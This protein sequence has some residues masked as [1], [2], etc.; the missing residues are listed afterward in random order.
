M[1]DQQSI[2]AS[3]VV[4]K[5]GLALFRNPGALIICQD[6]IHFGQ[7]HERVCC[8]P[9]GRPLIT[10]FNPVELKAVVLQRFEVTR[11]TRAGFQ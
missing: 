2:A 10:I 4:H 5:S 7:H 11:I 8:H 9:F 6:V 1:D 3:N